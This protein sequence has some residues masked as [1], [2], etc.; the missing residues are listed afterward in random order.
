METALAA[1]ATSA[2][3]GAAATA[4]GSFIGPVTA[5]ASGAATL[6]SGFSL[7]GPILTV[8]SALSSVSSG[9]Q[10]AAAYKLQAQQSEVNA[11]IEKLNAQEKANEIRRN[12]LANISSANAAYAARGVSIFSGT[13]DQARTEIAK[14]SEI[15]IDKA[16]FGGTMAANEKI[17]QA[18][19]Y[20]SNASAARVSG[21]GG[22]VKSLASLLD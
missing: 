8:G 3:T 6:S 11:R 19:Q 12:M 13:P 5:A 22:A 17:T 2:G 18:R 16:R 10:Q 1:F 15:N 20:K 7:L 4:A 14:N 9:N 21:Y